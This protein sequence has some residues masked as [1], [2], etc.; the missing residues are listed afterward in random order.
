MTL[1]GTH[2]LRGAFHWLRR[3]GYRA[4]RTWSALFWQFVVRARYARK[5]KALRR[6]PR[7]T[8]KVVFLVNETSKWKCQG[9]YDLLAGDARFEV[10]MLLTL[11][12]VDWNLS[13]EER[14]E[15][16][17]RNKA[18]FQDRNMA[19]ETAYDVER[20]EA[21]PLRAYGPDVVFYQQP[22]RIA[23]S[24][25]P[26]TVSKFALTL[27]VPYYVPTYVNAS[28]SCDTDFH[29]A[30]FAHFVVNDSLKKF[31]LDSCGNRY[32]AGDFVA[33]GHPMVDAVLKGRDGAGKTR[34]AIYAPHWTVPHPNNQAENPYNLS[35]FLDYGEAVLEFAKA[36]PE[37]KWIYKPHPSLYRCL[38]D[39]R[40]WSRERA[41][42]YYRQWERVGTACY[43]GGYL[44][45]F[46]ESSVLVT[47]CDSFLAEY[48]LTG[49]P[50]VHL[51]GPGVGIRKFSPYGE[52]FDTYY[53]VHDRTGLMDA[54]REYVVKGADPRKDDRLSALNGCGLLQTGA[55]ERIVEYVARISFRA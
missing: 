46:N 47:D 55:S 53:R 35:T 28:N 23:K 33:L 38:V 25:S 48:A 39:Y 20:D 4:Y 50:I 10:S 32:H 8:R 51:I 42:S 11:A 12:D 19:V 31:F 45:L 40:I 22:W 17:S 27:Y 43:D 52:L 15:K 6:D 44:P 49:K 36:H 3:K 13:K 24:Q 2:A 18:F 54:L 9:V 37:V 5:V 14:R 1:F 7:R 29:R 21:I 30:L 34:C 16:L 26:R 41:D